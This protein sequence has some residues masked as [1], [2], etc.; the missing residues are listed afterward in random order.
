ME[1]AWYVTITKSK[2]ETQVARKLEYLDVTHRLYR[3]RTGPEVIRGRY[4]DE[5]LIPAFNGYIFTYANAEWYH[6]I[7]EIDGVVNFLSLDHEGYPTAIRDDEIDRLDALAD[8]DLV[9]GTYDPIG[10][11]FTKGEVVRIVSG[12]FASFPGTFLQYKGRT[13]AII[14][15][16]MIFGRPTIVTLAMHQVEQTE[17]RK[18][19]ERRC[20]RLAA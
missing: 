6:P 17:R 5:R 2:A 11:P 16:V 14:V 12:P 1:D 7:R 13:G 15:E 10:R 4:Y 20:N 19:R 18:K 9:F 3:V 8:E